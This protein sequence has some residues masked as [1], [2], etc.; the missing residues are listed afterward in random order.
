MNLKILVEDRDSWMQLFDK[1][2]QIGLLKNIAKEDV[3]L[4]EEMF[5]MEFFIDIDPVLSLIEN[6]VV[7]PFK[8]KIDGTLTKC[9][10]EAIN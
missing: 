10:E 2:Q 9:L 3:D 1:F 8:K 5:P 6:P 7:K 4:D